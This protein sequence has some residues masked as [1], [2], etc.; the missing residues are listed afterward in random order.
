MSFSL[1]TS[2]IGH[3]PVLLRLQDGVVVYD[4]FASFAVGAL[5]VV[6]VVPRHV[7]VDA[8]PCDRISVERAL[9]VVD[10][11]GVYHVDV[12]QP[13]VPPLVA[14][15]S[16]PLIFHIKSSQDGGLAPF[17]PAGHGIFPQ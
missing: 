4:M 2:L 9:K 15:I 17:L 3:T 10:V 11:Y 5:H 1:L 6:S 12:A 13:E 16:Y 14:R 7:H 8:A